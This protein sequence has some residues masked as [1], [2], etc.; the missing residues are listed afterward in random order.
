[1]KKLRKPDGEEYVPPAR[2]VFWFELR[3]D[4]RGPLYVFSAWPRGLPER[5]DYEEALMCEKH[6]DDEIERYSSGTTFHYE[7]ERHEDFAI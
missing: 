5:A 7:W 6:R 2:C 4:C 1:M 3:T